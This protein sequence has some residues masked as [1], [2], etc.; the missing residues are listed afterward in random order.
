MEN[1]F[2]PLDLFI[3]AIYSILFQNGINHS[4]IL[5]YKSP[6]KKPISLPIGTTGRVIIS[7]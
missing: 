7:L 3:E 2:L 6:G 4:F 1:L 5:S